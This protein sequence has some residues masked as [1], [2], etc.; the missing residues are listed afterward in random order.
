MHKQIHKVTLVFDPGYGEKL[1]QL[2]NE[3]HVWVIDSPINSVTA[4]E[5]WV[6][7][8]EYKVELGITK[9]HVSENKTLSEICLSFLDAIDMHHN[10][11]AVDLPYSVLE[12]IGLSFSDEL[13]LA[14]E[15]LG[16][17]RFETTDR[18]FLAMR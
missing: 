13:K 15:D 16:F 2:A 11:D 9:F 10:E 8:P 5:Y 3:S 4:L 12:I 6:K 17:K 18:G 7:N 14:I 1:L